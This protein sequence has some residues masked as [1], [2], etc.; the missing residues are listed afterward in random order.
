[1]G[2]NVKKVAQKNSINDLSFNLTLKL[3]KRQKGDE[4]GAKNKRDG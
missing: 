1:M 4:A 3:S 2:F